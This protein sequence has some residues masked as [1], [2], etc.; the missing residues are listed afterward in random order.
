MVK[1]RRVS[2]VLAGIFV[3]SFLINFQKAFA[4]DEQPLLA[5][6]KNK[7]GRYSNYQIYFY[8]EDASRIDC[9]EMEDDEYED[10]E[11][12]DS[13]IKDNDE[14]DG[15]CSNID[16]YGGQIAKYFNTIYSVARRNGLP[17]EGIVAQLIGESG[18]MRNEVCAYNPLGLKGE[19]S[20]DGKHRTFSSYDEA[21]TYY[22]N[23]IRPVREAKGK[24]KDDPYGYVVFL[25]HG[26]P[27]YRYAMDSEYI[28][29]ISGY[30][31][32]VQK[33]AK[34]HGKPISGSG[35]SDVDYDEDDSKDDDT[36][37]YCAEDDEEDEDATDDS[38]EAGNLASYVKSWVWPEYHSPP[39]TERKPAYAEYMDSQT[40]YH[41]CDGI[42]C[43]AFVSNIIKASG[44]DANYPLCSSSCQSSWLSSNWEKVS[45][46]SLKLGD[47]GIKSGHVILYIGSI[48]GF[49]S[50]TA[51][52]SSCTGVHKRAPTAGSPN[53]NLNNYTWY[54][55]P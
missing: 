43:G 15:H 40:S 17:W 16:S 45:V 2:M 19:P 14:W 20:C 42:D 22:V 47:V 55:K 52:A 44:W 7:F 9:E 18:F 48:S 6:D 1:I 29:K 32:G 34:A 8:D 50:K 28:N 46:G 3:F 30:V 37:P 41:P 5:L 31:C 12:D 49:S 27:G 51:S 13:D 38:P 21:F 24:F 11:Y 26:V 53:E 25:I 10:V 54:R 39:F 23:S 35:S 4:I 33:W 36:V